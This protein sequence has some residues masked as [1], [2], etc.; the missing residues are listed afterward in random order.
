MRMQSYAE[1]YTSRPDAKKI[2]G[3]RFGETFWYYL[4][5]KQIEINPPEEKKEYH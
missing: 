4:H 1:I 5:Y 2:L 3:T